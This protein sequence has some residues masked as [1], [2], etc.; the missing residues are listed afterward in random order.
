MPNPTDVYTPPRRRPSVALSNN[1][2][3]S[4]TAS[5]VVRVVGSSAGATPQRCQIQALGLWSEEDG[6]WLER[7]FWLFLL[8]SVCGGRGGWV[9]RGTIVRSG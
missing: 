8:G 7:G 9:Y 2:A 4:Y 5:Q 6:D 1:E 3:G